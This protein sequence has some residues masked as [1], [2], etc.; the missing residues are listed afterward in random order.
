MCDQPSAS[1]SSFSS[2]PLS[3]LLQITNEH[4]RTYIAQYASLSRFQILAH[5]VEKCVC[6]AL[7]SGFHVLSCLF[8]FFVYSNNEPRGL[9]SILYH[10]SLLLNHKSLSCSLIRNHAHTVGACVCGEIDLLLSRFP[11]LLFHTILSPSWLS[12]SDFA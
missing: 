10:L 8:F 2:S 3:L 6:C 1:I 7:A 12:I 4:T 11:Y 5:T 9:K